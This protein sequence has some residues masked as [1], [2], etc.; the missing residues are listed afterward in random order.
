M[1]S[2]YSGWTVFRKNGPTSWSVIPL[3]PDE[4]I[5]EQQW[6][7]LNAI[8]DLPIGKGGPPPGL[9][10]GLVTASSAGSTEG[11]QLFTSGKSFKRPTLLVS[12]LT[13]G[14][15]F[16][17]IY[18]KLVEIE[19]EEESKYVLLCTDYTQNELLK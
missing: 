9:P 12:D 15:K 11:P 19:R 4:F 2:N 14:S 17:D 16:F 3:R 10:A 7:T 18:L 1:S 13:G 8:N 6:A 5:T